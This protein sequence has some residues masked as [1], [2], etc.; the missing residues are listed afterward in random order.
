MNTS[1]KTF[2]TALEIS[3]AVGIS[4]GY[5]YKII[6]DLNRELKNDGYLIISG[7]CPRRYF[8][9]KWYGFGEEYKQGRGR[10]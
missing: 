1:N 6:R 8:E 5:A 2:I 7:K 10:K 9:K 3:E 4:M